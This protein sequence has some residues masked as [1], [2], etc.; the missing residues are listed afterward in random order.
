MCFNVT[1]KRNIQENVYHIAIFMEISFLY[2][3]C[4]YFSRKHP[5]NIANVFC[6]VIRMGNIQKSLLHQL[7]FCVTDNLAKRFIHFKQ[8]PI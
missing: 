5:L 6:K 8:A 4:F 7:I 3:V 1:N 2:F